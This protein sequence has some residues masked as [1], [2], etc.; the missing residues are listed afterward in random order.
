MAYLG[1]RAN[2][3]DRPNF[4][5][6]GKKSRLP[7]RFD[8]CQRVNSCIGEDRRGSRGSQRIL[9]LGNLYVCLVIRLVTCLVPYRAVLSFL[10]KKQNSL[11]VC[12]LSLK[13][14]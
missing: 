1:M 4:Y 14:A 11:S 12:E 6:I 9:E 13:P 2:A 7:I 3:P 10:G 8:S 5:L